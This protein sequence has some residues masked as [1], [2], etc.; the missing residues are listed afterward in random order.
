MS[1]VITE[2]K[3]FLSCPNDITNKTNI[4][5]IVEEVMETA[6]IFYKE[7]LG[8]S[9][10]L[11]FWKKDSILGQGTPRVQDTINKNLVMNCDI[12]V[13][14]LWTRFG[15]PPGIDS[16]GIEYSSGTEEEFYLAKSLNKELWFFFYNH[17]VQP[18]DVKTEDLERV[19]KFKAHLQDEKIWYAEISSEKDF[20]TSLYRCI[21][22]LVN[23]QPPV[24]MK[25]ENKTMLPT[26][27]DFSKLNR[28][29]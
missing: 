11:K 5:K 7:L 16:S 10:D 4:V 22:G 29:F 1:Q 9:F 15:S 24:L 28:G 20:K 26:K 3:V 23:K 25:Q 2:M 18:T 17:Q 21:E 14:V 13:G 12:Y 27:D 6:N 8:I 19:M